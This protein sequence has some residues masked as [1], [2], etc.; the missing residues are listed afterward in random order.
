MIVIQLKI[1][2]KGPFNF[3]LDT[4]VGLMII[5]D[6]TLVDSLNVYNHRTLKLFGLGVGDEFEAYATAPLKIEIPGI[7][8]YDVAAAILKKD[9]FL[10]S[11]YAGM[12]IHGL[13]GYEFFSN[14]AVKVDFSDSTLTLCRPKDLHIIK[15]EPKFPSLLKIGSPTWLLI[16]SFQMGLKRKTS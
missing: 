1:N 10:L 13:L 15:K 6:P 14:L 7:T 4:G 5:T 12:P 11:N 8:S 2:G 3:V 9:H 16:L